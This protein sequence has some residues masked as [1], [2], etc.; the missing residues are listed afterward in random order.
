MT[1][2]ETDQENGSAE[3]GE[4]EGV[5]EL[6]SALST[7]GDKAVELDETTLADA[8]EEDRAEI[9]AESAGDI[10][11]ESA[12]AQRSRRLSP[13]FVLAEFHCHDGTPVPAAALPALR[14]LVKEVLEPMRGKFGQCKVNSAYRTEA[15][16]RSVKG[17]TASQH[18][19]D[20]SPGDVA[21]D[22]RFASG[23][24]RDWAAEAERRLKGGGGIGIYGTF[25]HVD[26]RRGP[27]RWT[28]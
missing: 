18:L 16:N 10:A 7:L 1:S 11:L 27:A 15:Y 26:N 22:V 28:G 9:E 4:V 3:A 20:Q 17:A 19:Y 6:E 25:T 24:P 21:A 5:A 2:T 14:R 23:T 8:S 13:H 12:T